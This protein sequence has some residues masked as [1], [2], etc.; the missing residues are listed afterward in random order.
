M[1]IEPV[2]P[3]PLSEEPNPHAK[4]VENVKIAAKTI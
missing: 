1:A 4:S 3:E 2:E